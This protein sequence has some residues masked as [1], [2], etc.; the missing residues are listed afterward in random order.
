MRQRYEHPPMRFTYCANESNDYGA[1]ILRKVYYILRPINGEYDVIYFGL[2]CSK[3]SVAIII[4]Y[5]IQ[6]SN[7]GPH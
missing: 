5:L 2:L 4:I 1:I 7:I 6:T 3:C